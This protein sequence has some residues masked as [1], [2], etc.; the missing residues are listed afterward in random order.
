MVNKKVQRIKFIIAVI[1]VLIALIFVG[2]SIYSYSKNG[3]KNMPF[4]LSKII[5]VSTARKYESEDAQP[6]ELNGAIWNFNVVQNNDMYIE[7]KNNAK[8]DEKI[9]NIKI[10][11]IQ[12]VQSPNKGLIKTYMPNSLDGAR[13]TYAEEYLV[14]DSLTYRGSEENS[15]KDLHINRKGGQ[16]S[17]SFANKDLGQY[18]SGE[19]TEVTYDGRML[20]KMG[21]TDDDLKFSVA[22]D[23]TIELEDGKTYVGNVET[24]INCEGLVEN[25]MSKLEVNDFSNV[26]FIRI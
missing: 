26:I 22:F 15:Y 24:A 13:Y 9:K 23:I 4:E 1:V 5:V 14:N 7:L 10:S 16:L 17:I 8:E 2:I 11:N 12:V 25:G 3:E 18:S 20:A 6:I 19:E 21:Y